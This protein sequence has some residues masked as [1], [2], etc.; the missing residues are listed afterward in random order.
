MNQKLRVIYVSAEVSP[1][2]KSGELADVASS[3]PKYLASLGMEVAVFM[4]KYRKPEIESLPKELV[5]QDVL[6]PMGE[7][8]AKVR[9]YKSELGKYDLYLVDNPQ[10]FWRENIYGTGKGEYLDND[11]RF[12]FFNRAV[13]EFLLKTKMP[14]DVIHCNNWPTALIPVFLKTNYAHKNHF[15]KV[16]TVFTLH[17]IAYQGEFPAETLSLAGLNWNNLDHTQLSYNGKFNF[18]KTGLIYSDV[19]NT[20]S[21]SYRRESL[22]KKYCFGLKDVLE[23]RRKIFFSIRNGVDYDIWNPETDPYIAANYTPSNLN[24]K[25]KCKLDLIEE[26]GLSLPPQTP[27]VGIVS[28]LSAQKGFDILIEAMDEIVSMDMG[29]VILGRGDEKYEKRMQEIQKQNP[30]KVGLRLEMNPALAHKT[31]A[32]ADIFLIPSLYEPCGLNQL[33]SFRYGTVPVVRATGGLGETVKPFDAK[34]QKGNGFIFREYTA[35]ALIEALREALSFYARPRLWQKIIKQGF[36]E[37]YSWQKAAKKYAK[38]YR[39]AL[40][41]R[42][43]GSIGRRHHQRF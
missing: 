41:M 27:L 39:N 18:L 23:N 7:K 37:D 11:E 2:A 20:V 24:P 35:P 14:V 28:Y 36:Q 34:N 5:N 13:L 10:Y 22:T 19:L 9:I 43:G 40:Q 4:P 1:F 17:N 26:F 16:A 8:K 25:K 3:L 6:V 31:A 12:I 33:Y 15:K 30:Q 29:L 32:G 21:S 42:K 38:L